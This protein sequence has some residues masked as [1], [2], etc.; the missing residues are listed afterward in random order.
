M[1]LLKEIKSLFKRKIFIEVDAS[2]YDFSYLKIISE[3]E[4][5]GWKYKKQK[6]YNEILIFER[7]IKE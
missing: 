4:K 6:L 3:Y 1:N 7:I 5:N 2:L